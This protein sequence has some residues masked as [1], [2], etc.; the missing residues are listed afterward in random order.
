MQENIGRLP[1][2][3]VPHA[4]EVNQEVNFM[5][6]ASLENSMKVG[7][8]LA[9]DFP[10]YRESIISYLCRTRATHWEIDVRIWISQ[11]SEIYF[12]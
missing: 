2:S 11:L 5:S 10:E 9:I 1:L 3:F 4:L 8:K 7:A 12:F 6:I